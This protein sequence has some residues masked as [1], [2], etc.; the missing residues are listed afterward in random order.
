[1]AADPLTSA[2]NHYSSAVCAY[3]EIVSPALGEDRELVAGGEVDEPA[4][5][6]LQAVVERSRVVTEIGERQLWFLWNA[7]YDRVAVRLLA[8]GAVDIAVACEACASV[9]DRPVADPRL[10]SRGA[11]A[12]GESAIDLLEP[13]RRAVWRWRRHRARP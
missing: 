5:R 7:E 8:A 4:E 6:A 10:H 12:C 2:W 13:G 11:P 1:M 9:P 3:Y